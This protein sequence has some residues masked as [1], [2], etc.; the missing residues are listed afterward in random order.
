MSHPRLARSFAVPLAAL[1]LAGCS[2]V[3]SGSSSGSDSSARNDDVGAAAGK[4]RN[5]G[6]LTVALSA[7]P[8]FLDPTLAGSLY[9]RYIFNAMCEKLYDL[10]SQVHIV[11]QLAKSLPKA[12]ADGKTVTIELRQG[13][14]FADGTP[15]DSAAVKTTLERDLTN[16]QSARVSELGPIASIDATAPT[17]V[18]IHLKTPFSPL[19]AALA[20]RSGMIM[21]PTQLKAKGDD[22][23]N[24]PV[25]VGPFK[26]AKRVP[27]NSIELVKDP[28]YYDAAKVHLDRIVYRIITDGSIRAANLKS[29]DAQVA[30]TLGTDDVP[31]IKSDANLSVLESPSLGYQGITFN[32]GNVAG[33]GKPP[34]KINQPYAKDPRIRQAFEYS[35]DR[36]ALIDNVFDGLFD[37]ACG[38][39][40]PRSEFSTDAVQQCRGYDPAKAKQ[41]LAQAGVKTP[42]RLQMLVTNTPVTLQFAQTLQAMVK[43]GGFDMKIDPVEFTSLLDQED[44]GKFS[45]LQLG[46]SGRVDPDANTTNFLGTQGSQNVGGYSNPAVDRLL[47]QA[48]QSQDTAERAKLYGQVQT[49][50]QQDV[51]IIYLYRQ[52]NL[53]GLSKKVS[54]VQVY[55]DGLIRVAFAGYTS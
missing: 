52:R 47:D 54:G 20:D 29:G 27:Q 42:Y 10:D 41:L 19:T 22:F 4:V 49:M 31:S 30:D 23:G 18:T 5:G 32:I 17:T 16:P 51:P 1:L 11:P 21:S 45:V 14:T 33:V 28:H 6:T 43:Q 34:G 8:D 12:S 40:S 48:R 36:K 9:S 44:R 3:G 37:P 55:A 35:I 15:L 39:V 13:I 2:S 7:E 24:A 46:W 25:C 53:T 50:L 26:L 38:P